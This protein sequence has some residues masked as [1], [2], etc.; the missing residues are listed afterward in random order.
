MTSK[1]KLNQYY[2]HNKYNMACAA[3]AA[4]LRVGRLRLP[5]QCFLNNSVGGLHVQ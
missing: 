3:I 4:L 1:N 5:V 2:M